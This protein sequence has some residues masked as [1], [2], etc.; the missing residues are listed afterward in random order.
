MD[1]P[2]SK[3]S[4]SVRPNL[5]RVI[6]FGLLLVLG[7]LFV[8]P[9]YLV[10]MLVRYLAL[11]AIIWF[12][13]CPRGRDVLFVYS[14]SPAWHD[15]IEERILPQLGGRAVVLNWSHRKSWRRLSVA[16]IAFQHFGGDRE[17][18]PLAVVFRPFKRT[19]SYRFWQPFRDFKRGHPEALA[20]L[21]REFFG[22]IGVESRG[23]HA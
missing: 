5:A 18:N 14:D 23:A 6:A 16:R 7:L 10:G 21:E 1:E 15:Y 13:W 3:S 12:W 17:F 8:L 2:R 11:H 22:S 20:K 19:Q 9:L 4:I